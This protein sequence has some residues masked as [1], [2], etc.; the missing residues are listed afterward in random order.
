MEKRAEKRRSGPGHGSSGS[1]SGCNARF[2]R[3]RAVLQQ[4]LQLNPGS[5]HLCQVLHNVK[6]LSI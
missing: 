4:G 6:Q 2:A 3:C 1:V 5:A